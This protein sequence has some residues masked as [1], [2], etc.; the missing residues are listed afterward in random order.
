MPRTQGTPQTFA[1]DE[2]CCCT[3]TGTLTECCQTG[4][5]SGEINTTLY[6][7]ISGCDNP[8]LGDM[9]GTYELIYSDVEG[10]WYADGTT[11][12]PSPCFGTV[13]LTCLDGVYS[14]AVTEGTPLTGNGPPSGGVGTCDPFYWTG[15]ALHA[16]PGVIP[17]GNVCCL[18]DTLTWTIT[19]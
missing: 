17:P 9:D 7:T 3:G 15:T 19:E 5:G 13:L 12:L 11:G 14:L 6:L 1:R 10:G 4:T 18:G 2:D 16:D 8:D